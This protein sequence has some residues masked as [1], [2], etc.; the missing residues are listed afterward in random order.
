MGRLDDLILTIEK[1][2]II[3]KCKHSYKIKSGKTIKTINCRA[4]V[5][6]KESD[7]C[8][9]H[10]SYDEIKKTSKEYSDKLEIKKQ[11]RDKE[12]DWIKVS[13]REIE[14]DI[15]MRL[16]DY[17]FKTL[18]LISSNIY[19]IFKRWSRNRCLVIDTFNIE[20]IKDKYS[21]HLYMYNHFQFDEDEE[22]IKNSLYFDEDFFF[23]LSKKR[24]VIKFCNAACDY[25]KFICESHKNDIERSRYD[26]NN[27]NRILSEYYKL[28]NIKKV[29]NTYSSVIKSI[30]DLLYLY[31]LTKK[32]NLMTSLF[33][34]LEKNII[35]YDEVCPNL[36]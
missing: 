32:Y 34:K 3:K 18:H 4:L 21:Y 16:Y 31:N 29:K 20:Q 10:F 12:Y 33:D 19:F 1:R 15:D 26:E 28:N 30:D 17:L 25:G 23:Y 22:D 9:L 13:T 36:R 35:L 2:P 7:Y 14:Y 6:D 8:F 5:Y 27:N 24:K 11:Q